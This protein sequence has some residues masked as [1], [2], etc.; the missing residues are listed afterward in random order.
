MVYDNQDMLDSLKGVHI[1]SGYSWE[2]VD[3]G[4]EALGVYEAEVE[5]HSSSKGVKY[6]MKQNHLTRAVR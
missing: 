2:T 6:T 5:P 1:I 4:A 3:R